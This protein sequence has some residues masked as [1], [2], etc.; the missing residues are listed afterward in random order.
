MKT[1][2][3]KLVEH[4]R[5][6]NAGLDARGRML[7]SIQLR[8]LGHGVGVRESVEVSDELKAESQLSL[9]HDTGGGRR[10]I[11]GTRNLA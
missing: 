4:F 10:I 9:Q 3:R 8:H 6:K 5:Y 2:T 1:T 7:L 11:R